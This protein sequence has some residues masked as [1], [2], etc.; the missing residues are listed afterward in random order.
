MR[1]LGY[2]MDVREIAMERWISPLPADRERGR[3]GGREK[4]RRPANCVC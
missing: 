1:G 3:E 4:G 2:V